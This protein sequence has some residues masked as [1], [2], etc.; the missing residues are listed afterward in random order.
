MKNIV[1]LILIGLTALVILSGSLT[2]ITIA[3]LGWSIYLVTRL[4]KWKARKEARTTYLKESLISKNIEE[5]DARAAYLEAEISRI[6]SFNGNKLIE[7]IPATKRFVLDEKTPLVFLVSKFKVIGVSGIRLYEPTP[8]VEEELALL[9][10]LMHDNGVEVMV[11]GR[12][13]YLRRRTPVHLLVYTKKF[14]LKV[15]QKVI[16]DLGERVA[17]ALTKLASAIG[18]KGKC[19]LLTASELCSLLEG[20]VDFV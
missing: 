4:R 3:I 12:P 14:T 8:E 1:K 2:L 18:D 10:D 13:G 9:L 5:R 7:V 19:T 20:G 6:I 16:E 15:S 17:Y 11:Y